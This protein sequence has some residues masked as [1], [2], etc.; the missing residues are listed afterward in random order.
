MA[1]GRLEAHLDVHLGPAPFRPVAENAFYRTD[2]K[3]FLLVA[4]DLGVEPLD[5]GDEGL[6]VVGDRPADNGVLSVAVA[7][8]KLV[9]HGCDVLPRDARLGGQE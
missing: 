2:K 1:D 7:V 8:R 4:C 3:G 6:E 5:R 9:A